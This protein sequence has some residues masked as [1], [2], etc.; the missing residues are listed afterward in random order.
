M[1][2][3]KATMLLQRCLVNKDLVNNQD[4]TITL[5]AKLTRLPLA[6][7]QAAAYINENGIALVDYLS[8]LDEQEEDVIDLLSEDFEDSGSTAR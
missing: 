2:E 8:L 5:L 3:E 7:V 4:D 1:D 6:I